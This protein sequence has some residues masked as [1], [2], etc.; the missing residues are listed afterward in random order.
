[1]FGLLDFT[2]LWPVLAWCTS[3][4]LWT[5]HFINCPN[6]F[7]LQQTMDT[8]VRL[9]SRLNV[10]TGVLKYGCRS[11]I[12][13]TCGILVSACTHMHANCNL[14]SIRLLFMCMFVFQTMAEDTLILRQ[15]STNGCLVIEFFPCEGG[16]FC[17][18]VWE[19]WCTRA[20]WFCCSLWLSQ[21]TAGN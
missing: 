14:E 9:Y 5:F 20:C 4:N 13:H 21:T 15:S 6:F 19:A 18:G 16:C 11:I 12:S 10:Y 17:Y 1:M 2:L 8:E 7:R 3:G